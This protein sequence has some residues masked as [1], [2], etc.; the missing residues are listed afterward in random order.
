[1]RVQKI[2][3]MLAATCA[4]ALILPSSGAAPASAAPA[5][6]RG[7]P[8]TQV[9]ALV[10]LNIRS[11]PGRHYHIVG[12]LHPGQCATVTGLSDDYHWWRIRC[13][14]GGGC[15]VSANPRY[16]KPVAWRS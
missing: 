6:I 4:A 16:S 1:M 3:S 13:P 12:M 9:V 7:T 2:I 11:G 15:W 5:N 14:W 10:N 8:V